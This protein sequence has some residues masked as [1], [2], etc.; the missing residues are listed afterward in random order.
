MPRLSIKKLYAISLIIV[1][2]I[3]FHIL[4][5]IYLAYVRP[6][7]AYQ[8]LSQ[9]YPLDK[10]SMI[11][12]NEKNLKGKNSYFKYY[13][14]PFNIHNKALSITIPNVPTNFWAL[15][16]Y[17]TQGNLVYSVNNNLIH[18]SELKLIMGQPMQLALLKKYYNN[19]NLANYTI[20]PRDLEKGLSILQIMN[21]NSTNLLASC[22]ILM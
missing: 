18:H 3:I 13:I 12:N 15:A 19:Q 5:I 21:N 16:I 1:T 6:N 17:N 20:V 4:T 2:T 11:T 10:F 14:C 9:K 22:K 7:K 8:L